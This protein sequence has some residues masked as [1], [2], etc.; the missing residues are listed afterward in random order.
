MDLR[1]GDIVELRSRLWRV[2]GLDERVLTATNID[3]TEIAQRRFFLPFE[4]PEKASINPPDPRILGDP[5]SNKLLIQACRYSMLHGA[6]PLLSLQR[7]SVIPTNYQLVPVV[8]ALKQSSRVRMMI[9][10]DVGLGKT[11]EAG[12]IASEL[13]ARNLASRVLVVCPRNLREQWR[14]ALEYFFH[15]DARVISSLHRR[16]LERTL[17]P[18][19][20]PWEHYRCLVAS[21]DYVKSGVVKHQVLE[22]PWDL[23]IVDEAHLAAKPHQSGENQN[24]SMERYDFVREL[25]LRAKHLLFLTATPHNGYTDSYASL[26]RML[27]PALVSGSVSEPSINRNVAIDHICQRRRK[28]VEDWFKERSDEENPFPERVQ[29]EVQIDLIYDEEKNVL[30]MISNYGNKILTSAEG[31]SHRV[32]TTAKWTVMHLHKRAL[33]SPAALRQSLKNRRDKLHREIAS[34]EIEDQLSITPEELKAT[35]LDEDYGDETTDEGGSYRA[36]RATFGSLESKKSELEEL[37]RIIPL[38]EKVTPAKDSKLRKLARDILRTAIAGHYGPAKIIIFTRYK[39]TLDYLE[40]EIPRRLPDTKSDVKIITVYGDLNE[41]QRKERLEEFQ[42]LDAGILIATDCISEGINLQHMA[43]QM[44]HYELPWNPNRLEQRNGRIDRY[45]QKVPTV[46]IRTLVMSDTL[47]ATILKVLVEKARNIRKEYGFAPPFFGDDANVIDIIREMGIELSSSQKTLIN[48][49]G[50]GRAEGEVNPFDD[51]T[52]ERISAE[53]FYG[54][55]D[56]DLSEVRRRLKDTEELVGTPEDFQRFVL[57]GLK[58]LGCTI[59]ENHDL[60][61]TLRIYLANSPLAVQGVDEVI[62]QASFDPKVALRNTD[63][64]QLNAGHPLVRRVIE[65]IR[66]SAFEGMGAGYGRS[67]AAATA[68]VAKVMLLYHFLARFTVNTK[69]PSVIEEI[70]PVGCDLVGGTVLS[71]EEAD[72]LWKS[73]PAP[74]RRTEEEILKHLERAIDPSVYEPAFDKR[75]RERLEAIKVERTALKKK[76]EGEDLAWLEGIDDVALASRDLLSV[77]VYY[78]ASPGGAGR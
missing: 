18:G 49:G 31:G 68:D 73:K 9:A 39:D 62:E 36:D 67:A 53:S 40:R 16:G 26:L 24:V 77:N 52:V 51:E 8:M 76:F 43:N 48:F 10:D 65:L 45:G 1:A 25:S 64:V 11:I 34:Q 30:E 19:A 54:Q 14:E 66:Q 74:M 29:D 13:L 2:D 60:H 21:I 35:A 42:K 3:G 6:A 44:I 23:V 46:Y 70:V 27:D 33:S 20:S 71:A 41:A 38:A 69:P 72:A 61:N 15:I 17:S 58:S 5:S 75:L 78:P 56:V 22:V 59:E 55:A 47:D 4:K 50:G 32:Q 12:L 57:G 63:V 37:E 28:D 7:S